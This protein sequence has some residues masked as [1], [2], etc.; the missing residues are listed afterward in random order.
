MKSCLSLS[1]PPGTKPVTSK[2][3]RINLI[4]QKKVDA[5]LDQYLAAG[6]IQH[7]TPPWA[8]FLVVIPK[9]DESVRSRRTTRSST[10]WWTWTVSLYPALMGILD[11]LYKGNIFSMFN[12]NSAFQQIVADPDTV[13]LTAFCTPAQLFE[14]LQMLQGANTSPA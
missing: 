9:K 12:L 2:P 5:V 4:L 7:S 14:L 10:R 1:V 11:S 6:L 8:S 13:P 3:H